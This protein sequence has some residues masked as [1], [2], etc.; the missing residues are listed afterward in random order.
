MFE[1]LEPTDQRTAEYRAVADLYHGFFTGIM[2][3]IVTRKGVRDASEFTY[4]LF[5]HKHEEQFIPGLKKL[6]IQDLPVPVASAQFHYLANSI[7]EVRVEYMYES[8]QKAWIR[9]PPP[10]YAWDDAAIAGIPTAVNRAMLRG[11][12]GQNGIS[13]GNPKVGFV[14]TK[15]TMDGQ[16]GL[17]GY[18]YEFDHE[19]DPEARVQ[20]RREEQGPQFDPDNA[21]R[22]PSRD[23][24]EERLQKALRNFGLDWWRSMTLEAINLFGPQDGRYLSG[25]AGT[26]IGLH[27]YER[28]AR[29]LEIKGSDAAGFG[30]LMVRLGRGQGEEMVIEKDGDTVIIRQLDWRMM[31]E[32]PDPHPV[33]FEAWNRLWEGLL[34]AHNPRLRLDVRRRMDLG[35]EYFEW[36]V[37][38]RSSSRIGRSERK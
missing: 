7:G 5:R 38:P 23:W 21:P 20:Y 22:L 34:A 10:R 33:A 15:M 11:W 14:C 19:L 3:T 35:D 27:Y 26:L 16:S 9:Y 2:L 28:T 36:I 6:G 32:D 17:E 29:T 1:K 25:T 18:F 31:R 30:E 24:P 8:D 13:L 12:H 4:W 37:S